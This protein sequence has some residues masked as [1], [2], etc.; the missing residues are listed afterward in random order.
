MAY[1][2]YILLQILLVSSGS[3]T[4]ISS[5]NLAELLS[6]T[7]SVVYEVLPPRLVSLMP[8]VSGSSTTLRIVWNITLL[9]MDSGFLSSSQKVQKIQPKSVGELTLAK[10]N[11]E[12]GRSWSDKCS[13]PFSSNG[14]IWD[15][16]S[17]TSLSG[18]ILSGW[19]GGLPGDWLRFFKLVVK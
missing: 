17:L 19:A 5:T 16:V 7:K 4:F 6:L 8:G 3:R 13:F 18:D 12:L 11:Q 10:E 2:T 15:I 1:W 9:S 14:L